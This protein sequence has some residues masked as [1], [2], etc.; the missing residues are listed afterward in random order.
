MPSLAGGAARAA[1]PF[2]RLRLLRRLLRK[3]RPGHQPAAGALAARVRCVRQQGCRGRPAQA[4][5][6]HRFCRPHA[7]ADCHPAEGLLED[8]D[9]AAK[10]SQESPPTMPQAS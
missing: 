5:F 8:L 1:T 9:K 10:P 4:R 3:R 7:T 2:N 6:D